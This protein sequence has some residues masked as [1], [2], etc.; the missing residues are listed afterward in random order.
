MNFTCK[1]IR[2]FFIEEMILIF[3]IVLLDENAGKHLMKIS[4]IGS[5]AVI[6]DGNLSLSTP[7]QL[8]LSS[9]SFEAEK[10]LLIRKLK[11]TKL[12]K[13][14]VLCLSQPVFEQ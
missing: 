7:N 6:L 9:E 2:K 10:K 4:E 12:V 1:R 3:E 11:R 14:I 8:W 5:S 13:V